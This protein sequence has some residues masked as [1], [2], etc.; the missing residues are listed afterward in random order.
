MI[1]KITFAP[2]ILIDLISNS[3]C[4]D[5]SLFSQSNHPTKKKNTKRVTS[6]RHCATCVLH[7]GIFSSS[8]QPL[9]NTFNTSKTRASSNNSFE[10]VLLF[11]SSFFS[12]LLQLPP[13]PTMLVSMS[14]ALN[15][16]LLSVFSEPLSLLTSSPSTSAASSKKDL[17]C[18]ICLETFEEA[19]GVKAFRCKYHSFC[20]SCLTTYFELHIREGSLE[21]LVCPISSCRKRQ[22]QANVVQD[23]VDTD[24]FD[25]FLTVSLNRALDSMTDLAWCPKCRAAVLTDNEGH[26]YGHCS[27]CDFCFCVSCK[28]PWHFGRCGTV[29]ISAS[30]FDSISEH[31]DRILLAKT[32]K[33]CPKCQ[34]HIE[35]NGGCDH[36]FCSRC[37]THF[38]WSLAPESSYLTPE[39]K[40]EM[41]KQEEKAKKEAILEQKRELREI[42]EKARATRIKTFK[43]RGPNTRSCPNCR[44]AQAKVTNLNHM[45]CSNCHTAFCFD[46]GLRI[47]GKHF[48]ATSKCRQHSPLVSTEEEED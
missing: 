22:V 40:I 16:S 1:S 30:P 6:P 25:R 47:Q 28:G 4:C 13:R 3:L 26:G 31:E 34:V 12:C 17:Q 32:T 36:M 44:S 39:L 43:N 29:W 14:T 23:L 8:L 18:G 10:K 24:L 46:C 41:K 19:S 9:S 15:H 2:L 33:R 7:K 21:N 27:Q 35:K 5:W 38:S 20:S 42:Q 11:F 48:T 37:Q 45:N